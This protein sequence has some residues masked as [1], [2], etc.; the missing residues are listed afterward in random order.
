MFLRDE[1]DSATI[2][3]E[4]D[5]NQQEIQ[6]LHNSLALSETE[7]ELIEKKQTTQQ[8]TAEVEK[9]SELTKQLD[10]L[11]TKVTNVKQIDG[12]RWIMLEQNMKRSVT[13][14]QLLEELE[15]IREDINQ[16]KKLNEYHEKLN[17]AI[18]Y[19]EQ[20][21]QKQRISTGQLEQRAMKKSSVYTAVEI[22]QYL[23]ELRSKLQG[24]T[25]YPQ[26]LVTSL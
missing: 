4:W 18:S 22:D 8:T 17:K 11:A 7:S 20:I 19:I 10:G 15:D 13:V 12:L 9:W 6:Q 24:S 3:K 14:Q 16:L 1:P 5:E 25:I 23:A 21:L 2:Q 26:M